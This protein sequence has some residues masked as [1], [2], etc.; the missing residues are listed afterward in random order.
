MLFTATVNHTV[1]TLS[2]CDER[3]SKS[4]CAAIDGGS[5]GAY[6]GDMADVR[7]WF[8]CRAFERIQPVEFKDRLA[9]VDAIERLIR[10]C[11]R[12]LSMT[13]SEYAPRADM[14][15]ALEAKK[16]AAGAPPVKFKLSHPKPLPQEPVVRQWKS[17]TCPDPRGVLDPRTEQL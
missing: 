12:W 7:E 17:K 1:L 10:E 13:S 4:W 6:W 11:R 9:L 8:M 15:L 16:I 14:V 5:H 2:S 3:R